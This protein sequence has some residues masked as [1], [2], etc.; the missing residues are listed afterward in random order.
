LVGEPQRFTQDPQQFQGL[1]GI[2]LV[3]DH[4]VAL[5]AGGSDELTNLQTLCWTCN[6]RKAAAEGRARQALKRAL[7]YS[8]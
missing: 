2:G 3:V 5:S 8:R 7:G 1:V 6:S 4:V